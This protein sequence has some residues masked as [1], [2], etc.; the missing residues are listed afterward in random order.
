DNIDK[1]NITHILSLGIDTPFIDDREIVKRYIPCLDLPETNM[2]EVFEDTSEFIG[3]TLD[4]GGVVL[5]HCNA[6]ISRS[7]SVIIAY[8][9]MKKGMSFDEAFKLV[10]DKRPA[11]QPNSGE[12]NFDIEA[13]RNASKLF[14]GKHDFRTFMSTTRSRQEKPASFCIRSISNIEILPGKPLTV[15][16]TEETADLYNFYDFHIHGRSFLYKQVRRIIGTLLAVGCGKIT[17]RDVY[18]MITIPSK[19]SWCSGL[20]VMPPFALYLCKVHYD[21]NDFKFPNSID[22]ESTDSNHNP[23]VVKIQA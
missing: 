2:R 4:T 14:L 21:E 6:G 17:Q 18:Q 19:H 13:V 7:A 12:P 5:V 1:F 22:T 8:L 20:A 16:N 23:E 11:I 10:K 15:A 9:I 3:L